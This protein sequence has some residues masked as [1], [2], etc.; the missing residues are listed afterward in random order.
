MDDRASLQRRLP[1]VAHWRKESGP[2]SV[3][4]ELDMTLVMVLGL[5]WIYGMLV[6]WPYQHNEWQEAKPFSTHSTNSC[7]VG[8]IPKQQKQK[9]EGRATCSKPTTINNRVMG[10]QDGCWMMRWR[11]ALIAIWFVQYYSYV[12]MSVKTVLT[13]PGTFRP[14]NPRHAIHIIFVGVSWCVES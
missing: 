1:G 7:F 10:H 14:G 13:L 5:L 3:S 2:E 4:R 12:L 6:W 11:L 8:W 9:A